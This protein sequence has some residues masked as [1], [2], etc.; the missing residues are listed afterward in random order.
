MEKKKK[1][2]KNPASLRSWRAR[3]KRGSK[4][5]GPHASALQAIVPLNS[6]LAKRLANVR[7]VLIRIIAR[8]T[9]IA[10]GEHRGHI[11]AHVRE[12]LCR[13]VHS[14]TTNLGGRFPHHLAEMTPVL[15]VDHGRLGL[16]V[17]PSKPLD[18]AVVEQVSDDG[19]DV[20]GWDTGSN[21]LA[22]PATVDGSVMRVDA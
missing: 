13:A 10:N 6:G 14:C 22:I 9:V 8:W 1:E 11:A 5:A 2:E 21:V 3:D 20:V 4:E 19:G 15:K 16:L 7:A 17:Q 18:L 12:T